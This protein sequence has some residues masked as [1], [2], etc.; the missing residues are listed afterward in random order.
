MYLKKKYK[1]KIND[2]Y[3]HICSGMRATRV[4]GARYSEQEEKEEEEK[5]AYRIRVEIYN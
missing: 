3:A 4:V 1:I 5:N 2:L